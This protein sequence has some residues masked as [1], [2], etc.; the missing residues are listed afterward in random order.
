M[1]KL[2]GTDGVR[3]IVNQELTVELALGL[4]KAIGTFFGEGSNILLGRDARAGGDML[5]RAVESGLLSTGVRV[6]EGGFAPTP[7][8]QYAVKTLGYDGGVI[9]TASHNPR[10]HNGIKVLDRDGVEVSREKEDR[11]EEIYFSGRFNTIPWNRLTHDVKRDDR[12]IDT[13]VQGVLSHVDVEKIR[14]RN[15]KVLVDGA[16]S[17]GSISTPIVARLLGCKIFTLNAN[18]DPT[19]PARNPEPTMESLRETAGIASSLKVDLAVAHDGDADRAIFIDSKGRVQWGDRSGSLLSWWASR[20]VNFP[21]RVFTAV[22][23]SSLVQEFLSQYGIEVVWT[24]VGSVDIARKLIQEKGIA[25][26]EE[27]GGFIFPGHQYVR[28]GAMSLALML[29]MMA[30]EGVSSAELFDRLPQYHLVKT[31]VDLKPGMDVSKM[32]E[33]VERELGAGNQIVK[34]DGVKIINKD[35]WILVRKSGTEPIIRVMVE[36][37]DE[38]MAERLANQVKSIIGASS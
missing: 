15:F 24:K 19:F 36:A 28:D 33:R 5:S 31:K 25:G 27:N 7:A 32:Y 8:L 12:V 14:A 9:I 22:S 26:F 11:I 38:G 17:V 16:N 30:F 37:K 35:F 2:F 3:G 6:F 34:I 20:K 21:R 23:S 13:Y 18:L 29:E 4:G 1:G 10:E